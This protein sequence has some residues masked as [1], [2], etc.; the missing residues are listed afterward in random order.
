MLDHMG[1]RVKDLKASRR[2]YD[3]CVNALGL[4]TIDNSDESFLIGRSAEEPLPFIWVGTALPAFWTAAHKTSASPIHV[5][6]AAKDRAAVDRFYAAALDAG[7]I[8]NGAP[9]RRGP[10]AMNYYAA[11]VLDPDG[12]N[13]EAGVRE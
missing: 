2:F 13:V 12:N 1:F 5:A 7:G 11:F 10:E 9:G 4:A 3:A 8:D 6:F